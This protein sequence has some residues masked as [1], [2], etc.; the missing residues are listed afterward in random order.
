MQRKI[1]RVEYSYVKEK[2]LTMKQLFEVRA[3]HYKI[4]PV[5]MY[6]NR[7]HISRTWNKRTEDEVIV[8]DEMELMNIF[9]KHRKSDG[10]GIH[11]LF[12]RL[13]KY[14]DSENRKRELT[15]GAA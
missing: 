11:E 6:Y 1:Q 15:N 9:I 13:N 14:V 4:G 10:A 7:V 5:V 12:T 3:F 8:M 2:Y